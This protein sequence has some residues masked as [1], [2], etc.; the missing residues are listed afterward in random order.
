[1]S[2][3]D[4]YSVEEIYAGTSLRDKQALEEN[5]LALHTC[6]NDDA[7]KAVI[8]NRKA[9]MKEL[10]HNPDLCVFA[11]Q[12]HSANIHK[13]TKEDIGAGAYSTKDAIADCD[14]LYTREKNVLLGVFTAD[15]VPILIYDKA[16]GIIAAIHSGWKGTINEI[17]KKMLNT[18]IYDEDSDPN[19][20]YAYIGPSIDFFSFE[21]G[22]DVIEHVKNMSF[23]T[24]A[25]IIPKENGKYL[26]DNKRLNMQMLLDAGIPDTH[27][28]MHNA[29]TFENEE[30]FFSYR[31]NKDTGR[32]LTFILRK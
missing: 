25:F 8:E 30:D 14:A 1:M 24:Q 2:Y 32:N 16:Q 3:I 4:W 19:E 13:V 27:I 28:F 5:N 18:L 23:D 21:V 22:E 31:K 11:Y 29:D 9:L 6:D 10:N 20:L 15:C 26:L 7:L 12:T 17:T